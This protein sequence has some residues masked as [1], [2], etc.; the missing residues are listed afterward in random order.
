[1]IM[2]GITY[3]YMSYKLNMNVLYQ[4]I[5]DEYYYMNYLSNKENK[6]PYH[7]SMSD[8]IAIGEETIKIEDFSNGLTSTILCTGQ[9]LTSKNTLLNIFDKSKFKKNKK[10]SFILGLKKIEMYC[11]N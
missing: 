8:V 1:M 9:Y 3:L 5:A 4:K 7:T 11:N 2:V 6:Y 10:E